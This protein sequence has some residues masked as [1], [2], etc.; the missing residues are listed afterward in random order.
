MS[1]A[2]SSRAGPNIDSCQM[3]EPMRLTRRDFTIGPAAFALGAVPCVRIGNTKS[4]PFTT[5]LPMPQFVDA[6]KQGNAVTPKAMTGRHAFIEG[7][8]ART[9]GYSAPILGPVIRLRRG[10]EVQMAVENRLDKATTVHWHGL[11]A[12]GDNDAGPQ[13]LIEKCA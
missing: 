1:P 8:P 11:L 4:A 7:K 10:G 6:A 5:P 12:P 3:V 13:Q 2:C 9:Y